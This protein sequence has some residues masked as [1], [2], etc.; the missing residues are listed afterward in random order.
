MAMRNG[1]G[2]FDGWARTCH[3][4]AFALRRRESKPHQGGSK[5]PS[6]S[7]CYRLTATSE[8]H[9]LLLIPEVPQWPKSVVPAGCEW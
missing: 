4:G 2:R 8:S 1:W 9:G 3:G 7:R 5:T 6:R